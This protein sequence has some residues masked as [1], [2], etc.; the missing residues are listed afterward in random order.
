MYR[1][2]TAITSPLRAVLAK[3]MASKEN[4]GEANGG[5]KSDNNMDGGML[6]RK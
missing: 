6:A 3:I 4:K 5:G 1:K 2:L